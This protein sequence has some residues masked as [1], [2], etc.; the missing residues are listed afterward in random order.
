MCHF[1]ADHRKRINLMHARNNIMISKS[2]HA[3]R[4]YAAI[5]AREHRATQDDTRTLGN[6]STPGSFGKC[7]DYTLPTDAMV[8]AASFNGRKQKSYFVARDVLGE[9][10]SITFSDAD[11]TMRL[12]IEPPAE[13]VS[14]IFPWIE[15]EQKALKARR[16]AAGNAA[17]DNTLVS[18]L[19]LLT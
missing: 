11:L 3:G 9:W 19:D 17:V 10:M 12:L 1:A 16:D 7:Y 2:T 6:W 14:S 5:A 13:L 8:A 18:F 15:E 4:P